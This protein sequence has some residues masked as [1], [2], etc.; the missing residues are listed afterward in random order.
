MSVITVSILVS[1]LAVLSGLMC[2]AY[3]LWYFRFASSQGKQTNKAKHFFLALLGFPV[4]GIMLASF[5][6]IPLLDE[7]LFK[8]IC[9]TKLLFY[10]TV[11]ILVLSCVPALLKL[12]AAA[13]VLRGKKNANTSLKKHLPSN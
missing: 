5:L 6:V 3:S 13:D 9:E 10:S 8:F 4:P 7:Q 2:Y 12:I 1:G 11:T